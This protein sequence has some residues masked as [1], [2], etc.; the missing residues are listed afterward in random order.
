MHTIQGSLAVGVFLLVLFFFTPLN[1]SASFAIPPDS[2]TGED[3]LDEEQGA[4][5]RENAATDADREDS[6]FGSAFGNN[7]V[8]PPSG[9]TVSPP[10]G[11]VISPPSGG[12]GGGGTGALTNPLKAK[13]ITE[14]LFNVIEVLLIFAVPIIVFFIIYAGF[15]FVTARGDTSKISTA[16]SALT[17]AIIGGIIVL[18]AKIIIEVIKNTVAAF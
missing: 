8:S 6:D 14:F 9:N 1:T 3:E 16:K 17:W 5:Y 7:T 4:F 15:L 12:G 10:T 2:T 13:S 11:N 18:G